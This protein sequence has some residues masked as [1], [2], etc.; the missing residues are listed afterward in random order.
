MN[1]FSDQQSTFCP[2]LPGTCFRVLGFG[3]R[4]NPHQGSDKAIFTLHLPEKATASH[5][6]ATE[7]ALVKSKIV[8]QNT[9]RTAVGLKFKN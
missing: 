4:R 1:A 9:C 6:V 7:I 3:R 8:P 5:D 2:A